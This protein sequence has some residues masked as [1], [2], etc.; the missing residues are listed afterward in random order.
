VR[1]LA[2]NR[3]VSPRR[4]ALSLA[5]LTAWVAGS[6]LGASPAPRSA[7]AAPLFQIEAAH[8]QHVPA[9]TGSEPIFVLLIGSDARPGEEID[10]TRADS[11]HIVA[12]NPERGK[13]SIVGFPRDS[14]VSIPGFGTDKINAAMVDGGPE[15][16]VETVEELTGLTMDYW[17]LTWF[18]GFV[19][20]VRDV[21]GLSIDVPFDVFDDFAN[22]EI[23]AGRQVLSGPDALAFARARHALPQGDFGRSENQGRLM[24]AALTQFKKEFQQSPARMLTWI[25]AGLRNA[26]T[27][28]P[29]DEL[30]T[31]AFTGSTLDARHVANVVIPGNLGTA[32]NSSVVM[33]NDTVLQTI[34]NDLR[35]DG[36]IA[37][38]NIPPSPNAGLLPSDETES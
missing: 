32:G 10:R 8:A 29:L 35:A 33:L 30:L 27:D 15:L 2:G 17:A 28:V 3:F 34:S 12:I 11:I 14:Y 19:G 1:A 25:G 20:M 22:A 24:I 23:E 18:E 16:V 5:V 21:G 37:R 9:L 36:I 26:H 38:R 31:L 13:A 4:L 7:R 6:T